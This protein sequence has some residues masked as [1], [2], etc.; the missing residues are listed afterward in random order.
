MNVLQCNME[1]K[2]KIPEKLDS[3]KEKKIKIVKFINKKEMKIR[4][5]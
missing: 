4:K 1:E 5:N 2:I 3:K